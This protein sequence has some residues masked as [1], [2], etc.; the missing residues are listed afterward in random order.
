FVNHV[1][2]HHPGVEPGIEA[3]TVLDA[4]R[5]RY[6]KAGAT[7]EYARGCPVTGGDPAE[8]AEATALAARVDVVVAVMGDQSG[9]FGKGTS[10][11]G[12]DT[13]SLRLPGLQEALLTELLAVGTPVVLVAVTGRPYGIGHLAERAAATLQAFFPG[14]AGGSALAAVIAGD[15]PPQGRLPVSMP[16][17]VGVE[18]YSY[19]HANLAGFS[20]VTSVD[21]APA[22]A[23]GHGLSY[24]DFEYSPARAEPSAP[25]E[26]WIEA[27]VEVRNTGARRG[28]EVVQ[29]YARDLVASV[30]RPVAQL[31]GF[32]RVDLDVA[33]AVR[34]AFRVPT[35]R[36]AFHDRQMRRVV[37]PGAVHV[38]FGRSCADPAT[39]R[40]PVTLEGGP[41]PV[42]NGDPR[43]TEVTVE[44]LRGPRRGG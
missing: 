16:S 1:L 43:L 9:L 22:F 20:D 2:A 5:E 12:C 26:G 4:L 13:D 41:H 28:V 33:G 24:T 27:S 31:V 39:E 38:W 40:L 15:A 3:P 44:P 34:V 17:R 36:L 37:E 25:T 19:L 18:P 32:A 21:A 8:F 23:F 14:E 11:E 35:A 42:G 30:T 10:G 6:G 29:L 7:V